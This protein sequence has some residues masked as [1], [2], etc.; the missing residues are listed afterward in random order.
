M[1]ISGILKQLLWFIPSGF[2]NIWW[3]LALVIPLGLLFWIWRPKPAR[4][5]LPY[6]HGRA[7]RGGAWRVFL[8]VANSLPALVLAIAVF[9]L[10]GPQQFGDPKEKRSLTN[11]EICLDVSYSMT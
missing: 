3:L 6:D 2:S 1:T 8:D 9:L 11:I 4:L 10:A 7:G 5:V